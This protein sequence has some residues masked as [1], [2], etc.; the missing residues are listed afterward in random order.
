M[1]LERVERALMINVGQ[2][3]TYIEVYSAM[4][5]QFAESAVAALKQLLAETKV[6]VS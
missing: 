2:I 1:L 6:R 5:R 4:T 3:D